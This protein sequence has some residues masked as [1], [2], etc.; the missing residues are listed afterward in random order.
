M[1]LRARR[2]VATLYQSPLCGASLKSLLVE[3]KLKKAE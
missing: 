3:A 2:A 1:K